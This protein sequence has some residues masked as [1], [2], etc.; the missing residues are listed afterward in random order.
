MSKKKKAAALAFALY[1]AFFAAAAFAAFKLPYLRPACVAV[2]LLQLAFLIFL[3][4]NYLVRRRALR[5]AS[6]F[7]AASRVRNVDCLFIGCP[8]DIPQG[9]VLV[10]P[11]K[12][13]TRLSAFE[14]LR[15]TFS[16]VKEGGTVIFSLYNRRKLEAQG[17]TLFSLFF[18]HPVTVRRLHLERQKRHL[19]LPLVA[20]PR[21]AL[22][23]LLPFRKRKRRS[24]VHDEEI[25]SFANE[26]GLKFEMR[27]LE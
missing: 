11:D 13:A 1:L 17:F 8:Q 25:A 14:L 23:L 24:L 7:S 20:S 9:N 18:F 5:L 22:Q 12:A 4:L 21:E 2:M 27:V 6:L 16:I 3:A 10:L 26:R 15:H 19:A